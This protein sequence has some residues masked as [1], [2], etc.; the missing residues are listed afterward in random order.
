MHTSRVRGKAVH[1]AVEGDTRGRLQYNAGMELVRPQEKQVEAVAHILDDVVR[2]PGT[3]LRFGIDPILG[4]IPVVGDIVT[5][6]CGSFILFTA[7]RL[8]VSSAELIRMTYNQLLNGVIGAIPVVGD[9]YS[10]GFKS[11][12]KNSALLV[13]TIKQGEGRACPI[14]APSLKLADVWLVSALTLPVVLLAGFVGWWLWERNISLISFL[15][16]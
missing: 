15:F 6:I 2:I 5:V 1:P 3:S 7:C 10:F 8:G 14:V 4:L 13:R 16:S 11:H 12:A 9:I